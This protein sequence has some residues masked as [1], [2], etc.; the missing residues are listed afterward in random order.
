M[1]GV[2]LQR[3]YDI[4]RRLANYGIRIEYLERRLLFLEAQAQYTDYTPTLTNIPATV[5]QARW[6]AARGIVHMWGS[7]DI[8]GAVT[9]V[10]EIGTPTPIALGGVLRAAGES[11]ARPAGATGLNMHK[12]LAITRATGNTISFLT[13]DAT[14][15]LAWNATTPFTWANGALLNFSAVYERVLPT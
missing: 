2:T 15:A 7:L 14:P 8:T 9:G 5:T 11:F 13:A 4:N 12:G 6:A 10:I 3:D 1:A